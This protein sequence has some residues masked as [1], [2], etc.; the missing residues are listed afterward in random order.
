MWFLFEMTDVPEDFDP[1]FYPYEV[2]GYPE[3]DIYSEENVYS[4][5]RPSP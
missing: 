5:Y 1:M 2:N 3:E 4:M